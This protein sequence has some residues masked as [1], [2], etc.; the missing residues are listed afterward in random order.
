MTAADMRKW[1]Q[2]TIIGVSLKVV[3]QTGQYDP[4]KL[5]NWAPTVGHL[6]LNS[7][8]P[9]VGDIGCSMLME[10]VWFYT[11]NSEFF[12]HNQFFPGSQSQS[13]NPVAAVESHLSYDIKPRLWVSLDGNYWH[14]G[15]TSLNGVANPATVQNSSRIG[16]TVSIPISNR[17][18]LKFSYNNGAYINYGGNYQNVSVGWQ[19]SWLGRPN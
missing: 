3:A 2:K 11:T 8:I 5:V 13:E 16:A 14:G 7:A 19:Y 17:Q 9:I 12:S 4:T 10:P 1:K 6:N 15:E 18:S